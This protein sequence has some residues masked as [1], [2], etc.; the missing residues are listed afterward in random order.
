MA[1]LISSDIPQIKVIGWQFG[2]ISPGLAAADSHDSNHVTFGGT[3]SDLGTQWRQI[4]ASIPLTLD[5][6]S[7]EIASIGRCPLTSVK[8]RTTIE[9]GIQS[10]RAPV[11]LHS[12][13]TNRDPQNSAINRRW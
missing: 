9:R 8:L 2:S 5:A 12:Y 7:N 3:T 10:R 4:L 11:A 1:D 13:S 6:I